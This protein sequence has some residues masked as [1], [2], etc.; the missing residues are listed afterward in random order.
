MQPSTHLARRFLPVRRSR[1]LS[2]CC[3][4]FSKYGKMQ[5]SSFTKNFSQKY[6]SESLFHQFSQSTEHRIPDLHPELLSGGVEGQWLQWRM[7]QSCGPGWQATF[8]S[9]QLKHR[10]PVLCLLIAHDVTRDSEGFHPF[11]W[12]HL[13]SGYKFTPTDDP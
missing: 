5:E 12:F 10:C 8:F 6:L 2:Q 4:C 11:P 9:W 7:P 3:W 1:C 13:T